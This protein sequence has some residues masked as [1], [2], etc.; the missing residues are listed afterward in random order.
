[1]KN[2]IILCFFSICISCSKSED[3]KVNPYFLSCKINRV[4]Y[5]VEG[6]MG[7]FATL[8][9]P[10]TYWIY[11]KDAGT[12][13]EMYVRI[14]LSNWLGTCTMKGLTQ[15]FFLD[16]DKTNYHTNFNSGTG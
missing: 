14:E 1:M 11:G 5:R 8:K 10:E 13:K 15:A 16:A 3:E 4:A 12:G 9:T 6:E 7:A 2:I